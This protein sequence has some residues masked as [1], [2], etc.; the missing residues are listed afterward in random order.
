MAVSR[1]TLLQAAREFGTP[2]FVYDADLMLRRYQELHDVIAWPR[3][4]IHYAMKANYNVA[5]LGILNAAGAALDTVSPGEVILARRIGFPVE[6]ILYT[7]N[8]MTDA[9]VRE[10]QRTGVLMNIGSLSRLEKFGREFPGTDVC[11]RFNPDVVD[12][13]TAKTTTGGPATKFGIL[14]QDADRV[15]D[16]VSR[17]GLRVVGLHEHTGS[18]LTRESSV[19]RSMQNLMSLA[20]PARFPDLRFLDFG[21]GFKVPYRPEETRV[22]YAAMGAEIA[23]LFREF[24]GA[25]GRELEMRFEPGRYIVAE[26]GCLVIEVNTLKDNQGRLM[27]G[28][29]S[30]F[31]QL[32]RP[33]MYGAYHHI[34]NLTNPDGPEAV[35]DVC[36][37][38]CETGDRFAELRP[39]PEIREGDLLAIENAGAYCYS[40]GGVY[41]LRPMP[42]EV[43]IRAGELHLARRG[44]SN[45]ELVEQILAESV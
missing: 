41:N 4:T 3:L 18:G 33:V 13:E 21:G 25:Y 39:L 27:A 29:N 5:L 11:I 45:H 26:C 42:A 8:S 1:D 12:G 35:Y 6:R 15:A 19:Y 34:V 2:L 9:E 44:L 24:C 37:N 31:P 23:R 43:V 7:A 14:M 22:D 38:I 10:V 32:I 40:M 36:G 28:C 30:G 16:L 20:T 17:H